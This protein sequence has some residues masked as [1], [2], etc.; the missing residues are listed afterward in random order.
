ML[1]GNPMGG[2]DNTSKA[3][4]KAQLAVAHANA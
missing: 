2:C 4:A 3:S 1:S